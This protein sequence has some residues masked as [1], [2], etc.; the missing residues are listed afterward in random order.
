MASPLGLPWARVQLQ[1]APG[2]VNTIDQTRLLRSS[3]GQQLTLS[4]VR[5]GRAAVS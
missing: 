4:S 2:T 5:K 1:G 3:V